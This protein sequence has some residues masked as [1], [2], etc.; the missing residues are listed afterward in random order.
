MRRNTCAKPHA[1]SIERKSLDDRFTCLSTHGNH[2]AK[3]PE[4][5]DDRRRHLGAS[6]FRVSGSD[7]GSDI[8]LKDA[9]T[10]TRTTD[11]GD[12]VC[13][14][15]PPRGNDAS[16]DALAESRARNPSINACFPGE[17]ALPQSLANRCRLEPLRSHATLDTRRCTVFDRSEDSRAPRLRWDLHADPNKMRSHCR[18][19]PM[20][21]CSSTRAV[22]HS[23]AK[24]LLR[25]NDFTD[26][27][28]VDS[29]SLK[30]LRLPLV[31]ARARQPID[32]IITST[33]RNLTPTVASL[34]HV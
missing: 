10:R 16:F 22:G 28:Q 21:G 25:D 13:V 15:A 33:P 9:T 34:G 32:S 5:T 29:T 7:S 1:P 17:A 2:D 3:P 6:Y 20:R 14:T 4:P 24:Q 8:G 12:R 19:P 30:V 23:M 26:H 18:P 27:D 31:K 11:S